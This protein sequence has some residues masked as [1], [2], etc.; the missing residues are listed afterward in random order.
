MTG[1]RE[2]PARHGALSLDK[3]IHHPA[4]SANALGRDT[5]GAPPPQPHPQASSACVPEVVST[6]YEAALCLGKNRRQASRDL[7]QQLTWEMTDTELG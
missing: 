4:N 7:L 2:H 5:A 3:I 6:Y 1:S